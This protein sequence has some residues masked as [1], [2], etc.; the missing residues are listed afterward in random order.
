MKQVFRRVIDREVAYGCWTCRSRIWPGPGPRPDALLAD[1]LGH[2]DRARWRRRR[3]ELVKQTLSDP[4]MRNVVKQTV[5][6]TGIGPD[7]PAGVARDDHAPRDR[8]QRRRYGARP[9]RRRRGLRDRPDRRL[10]GDRPRRGGRAGHQPRRAGARRRRPAPRGVRHRRRHRHPG[11]AACRPP[12]RRGRS[13][14]TASGSSASSCARIA[15]AAGCVVVGIDINPNGERAGRSRRAHRS[16]S[17]RAIRSGSGG[18]ST[19]P[20]S[21]ASTPPSCAPARTP[22]R[23]STRRWRSPAGRAASCSS[24]T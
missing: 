12:V 14:S 7:G 10:R 19:S 5:F 13:P 17:T 9:R 1:Q 22:P 6:A 23:S 3:V 8:L 11:A 2:R 15:L 16:S 21:T 18:S 4:W 20:A 24:A